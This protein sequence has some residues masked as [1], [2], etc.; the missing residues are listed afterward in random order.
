MV[1]IRFSTLLVTDMLDLQ[2]VLSPLQLFLSLVLACIILAW[3]SRPMLGHPPIFTFVGLPG[4]AIICL[5]NRQN[6]LDI[7]R[8]YI[9]GITGAG[10]GYASG[11]PLEFQKVFFYAVFGWGM[12]VAVNLAVRN[13]WPSRVWHQNPIKIQDNQMLHT[14]H[15][16]P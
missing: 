4:I 3:A 7:F 13:L 10:V 15:P 11:W 2:R 5:A 16:T 12:A 8:C 14:E 9:G 1:G 6:L